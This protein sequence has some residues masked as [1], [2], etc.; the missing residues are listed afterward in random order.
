MTV[1]ESASPRVVFEAA[2]PEIMKGELVSAGFC[3]PFIVSTPGR[4]KTVAGLVERF[5]GSVS[6]IFDGA[7]EHVPVT[8]T[9][10]AEH[11]ISGAKP[12][13]ILAIGGGTAIGLGK[14]LVLRTDLPLA[15]VPTTYSGSEMT[16][17]YGT[18]DDQGKKTGRDPRVVPRLV[19]YD[20]NLTLDL[21]L[22]VSATSG[23][24]AMAHS[25]E[26]LY[27]PN[28]NSQSNAWAEES[29]QRLSR[30]LPEIVANQKDFSA[31]TSMLFGAHLA[32]RS[33]N[34]TSMGLHH[35]ICHVL[36][37]TY[38]MPHAKT[39]SVMLPYVVAFNAAAAGGAMERMSYALDVADA[40]QGLIDLSNLLPIPRSLRELGLTDRD[41]RPA[42]M[43]IA[44]GN[45]PNP[46]NVTVGDVEEILKAAFDGISPIAL[47]H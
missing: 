41:I 32:G 1:G 11:Q 6:G 43:K 29:I 27:A 9:N 31:R 18:S 47:R 13:S 33:L 23:M 15:A 14:A 2:G 42:A 25:V 34:G 38:N 5:E 46:R 20:V 37:G 26:A 8:V 35:K 28:A 12:D 40:V 19:M 39:H 22:V 17:I 44:A 24:N 10:T 45:Y 21:P 30:G 36:G 3:R 4:A 7:L 16:S